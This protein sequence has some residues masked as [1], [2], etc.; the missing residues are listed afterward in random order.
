ME[1]E[2]LAQHRQ[3]AEAVQR[4]AECVDENP[5]QRGAMN[6][7]E[8]RPGLGL[9]GRDEGDHI[10]R[11]QRPL[12]VIAR[13]DGQRLV[14][15]ERGPAAGLVAAVQHQVLDDQALEGVFGVGLHH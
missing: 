8:L 15:V 5:F 6:R 4:L 13:V 1:L 12:H 2:A 9:G 3:Q 7:L 10:R 11:D 14:R